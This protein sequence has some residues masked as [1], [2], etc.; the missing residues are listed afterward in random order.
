MTLLSVP[1]DSI[2]GDGR[3]I[4]LRRIHLA[5]LGRSHLLDDA[6]ELTR[7]LF[8][9]LRAGVDIATI[10]LWLGHADIRSTQAYLHADMS[11]KER[12]L[13]RTGLPKADRRRPA[14]QAE[15]RV[16]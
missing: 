12:A 4:E 16:G 11:M 7:E 8:N 13:T 5:F 3:V 9:L 6:L 1:E 14:R 15:R 2:V 10:A